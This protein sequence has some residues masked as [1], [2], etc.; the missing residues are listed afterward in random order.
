M[1][2]KAKNL[3]EYFSVE[4]EFHKMDTC[5]LGWKLPSWVSPFEDPAKAT[6]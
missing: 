4:M 6:H 1:L 5:V 2:S 3:F